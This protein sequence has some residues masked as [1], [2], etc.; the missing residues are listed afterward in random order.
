MTD[1]CQ[2]PQGE[3]SSRVFRAGIL[4]RFHKHTAHDQTSATL[5]WSSPHHSSHCRIKDLPSILSPSLRCWLARIIFVLPITPVVPLNFGERCDMLLK[6]RAETRAVSALW[7]LRTGGA[8]CAS[9]RGCRRVG[10][11]CCAMAGTS[12]VE[13]AAAANHHGG[14]QVHATDKF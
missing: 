8:R 9:Y 11:T 10:T 4:T 13:Q 3:Y 14:R 7:K 1:S 6:K 12:L 5:G 2:F